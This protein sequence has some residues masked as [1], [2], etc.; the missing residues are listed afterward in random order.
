MDH[1]DQVKFV[2]PRNLF[3]WVYNNVVGQS[4]TFQQHK[5]FNN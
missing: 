4:A 3:L 2:F 1:M 5:S